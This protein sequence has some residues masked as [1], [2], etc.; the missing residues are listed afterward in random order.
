MVS[1]LAS[2]IASR[3]NTRARFA[4]LVLP[5]DLDFDVTLA[6]DPSRGDTFTQAPRLSLDWI[7]SHRSTRKVA[8]A[9]RKEIFLA[10][11]P[12]RAA[13]WGQV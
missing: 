13:A 1:S 3:A 11:K 6:I 2:F 10:R 7:D 12:S 5:A 9:S 4:D 8:A